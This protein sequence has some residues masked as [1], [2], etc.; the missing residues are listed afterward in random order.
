MSILP[1]YRCCQGVLD[2]NHIAWARGDAETLEQQVMRRISSP[3]SGDHA[4]LVFV[5]TT[6]LK[7]SK[8]C[9]ILLNLWTENGCDWSG[10]WTRLIASWGEFKNFRLFW[11]VK[12]KRLPRGLCMVCNE[13]KANGCLRT[14]ANRLSATS[15]LGRLGRTNAATPR[16]LWSRDV[17]YA[18]EVAVRK[19]NY[20][21]PPSR[22]W[23]SGLFWSG[24][25]S[26]RV[27]LERKIAFQEPTIST[28]YT[29]LCGIYLLN[30]SNGISCIKHPRYGITTIGLLTAS[31]AIWQ[32]HG[33][34]IPCW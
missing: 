29:M 7:W 13:L 9:A 31:E 28:N 26:G 20:W 12:P 23:H 3:E 19:A 22:S 2:I 21:E 16:D 6:I 24:L 17:Y 15:L 10:A 27:L 8:R 5:V 32:Q 14:N 34:L 33:A 4:Q 30:R 11:V 18:W 1:R 25:G